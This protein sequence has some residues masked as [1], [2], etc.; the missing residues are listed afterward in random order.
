L[1]NTELLKHIGRIGVLLGGCSSEREV[2]IK[3]GNAVYEALASL[4][5]DVVKVDVLDSHSLISGLRSFEIDIA[6]ITL[7]GKFGEDGVVQ[8]LLCEN[9]IPYTGSGPESSRL[10]LDKAAAKKIF[11]QHNI[12]TP[13]YIVIENKITEDILNKIKLPAVVKP[14][15]EGSSIGMSI[16]DAYSDIMPAMEKA[17]AYD[18]KVIVED[19][20]QGEEIAVGILKEAP[21]PVI[22]IKPKERF[23]DYNSKYT[24]GGSSYIV[25]AALPEDIVSSAQSLGVSAHRALGCSTFSRVDMIVS[26]KDNSIAVLEVNTIP[27]FTKT[28]LLPKAAKAAG[29]DFPEMCLAMLEPLME[30]KSRY[31]KKS[32]YNKS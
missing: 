15:N 29:I 9:G 32:G 25:P 12:P 18:D 26:K 10:A 16:A 23:Y 31:L 24:E 2:S 8:S 6:F 11:K 19:Y 17:F 3:S 20:I 28:S 27:G 14:C 5:L 1:Y 7:H 13:D 30:F 21:L 4:G 22:Q